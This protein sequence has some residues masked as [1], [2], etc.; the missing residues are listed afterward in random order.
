MITESGNTLSEDLYKESGNGCLYYIDN[1]VI[2]WQLPLELISFCK[3]TTILTYMWH[4]SIASFYM[5][6]HGVEVNLELDDDS[7]F[8]KKRSKARDHKKI[9]AVDK[10]NLSSRRQELHTPAEKKT[11]STAINNTKS[12]SAKGVNLKYIIITCRK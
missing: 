10:L 11:V 5:R 4:G 7:Q 12:R 3:S 9:T 6:K 2:L 8:R 1:K